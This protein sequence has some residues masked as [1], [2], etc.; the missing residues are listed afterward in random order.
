MN[1]QWA[2][3][4]AKFLLLFNPNVLEVLA[5]KDDYTAFGNEQCQLVLLEVV[6][7]GELQATDFGANDGGEL[8]HF[9]VWVLLGE[10]IGLLLVGY[11]SAVVELE[12]LQ[13]WEAGLFIVDWEVGR[14]FVLYVGQLS[15]V[16]RR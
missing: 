1:V 12:R 14:V 10:E 8:G 7:L 4:P 6:E 11:Q 2:K 13:G 3:V 15:D 9:E 5:S 16:A